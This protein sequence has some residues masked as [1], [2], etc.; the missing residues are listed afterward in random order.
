MIG[1][2][3]GGRFGARVADMLSRGGLTGGGA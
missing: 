3:E 1:R 2:A